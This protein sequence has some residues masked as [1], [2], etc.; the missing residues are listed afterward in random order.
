MMSGLIERSIT[1]KY[2]KL[3]N[4]LKDFSNLGRRARAQAEI[5]EEHISLERKCCC[6]PLKEVHTNASAAKRRHLVAKF[7]LVVLKPIGSYHNLAI[8]TEVVETK[9]VTNIP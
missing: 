7:F 9:K 6:S 2:E 1:Y 4:Y 3:K 5:R 8:K